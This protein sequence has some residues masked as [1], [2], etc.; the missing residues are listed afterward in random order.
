[1]AV[2]ADCS[3]GQ[4]TPVSEEVYNGLMEA[5]A[6]GPSNKYNIPDTVDYLRGN[7]HESA[8][9]WITRMRAQYICGIKNG[10][11]IK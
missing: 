1:M 2:F 11:V 8:A 5:E 9:D 10:F 6:N 4:P 3:D 7:G